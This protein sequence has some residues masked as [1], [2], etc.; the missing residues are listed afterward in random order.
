[1]ANEPLN[2]AALEKA[3]ALLERLP[4]VD[5]HNDLPM[6]IQRSAA[7]GDV[8]AYDL[9]S[10]PAGRNTDIPRLR[11]GRVSAQVLA[12]HGGTNWPGGPVAA[13]LDL[14]DI[15]RRIVER[16]GDVFTLATRAA[17]IPAAKAEGK[18]A[19]IVSVEGGAGIGGALATLRVLY[20]AG[21]R[22]MT[23][24]HNESLDWIDSATEPPRLAHGITRFGEAVV[25]EMNR[26]GM[27]VDLSHVAP[28]AMR[29]VLDVTA[30][31][32]VWSHSNALSLCDHPRNVPDDVLARVRA[33]GGLVMAT[34]IPAF[35][36]QASRDWLKAY[37]DGWGKAAKGLKVD[38]AFIAAREAEAGP[39]PLGSLPELCDH[40]EHIA[41]RTGPEHLGIGCDFYP[42]PMPEGLEDA[43]C[44]PHILAELIRR[45]WS[46][47]AIAGVASANFL[48]VFEAVEAVAARLKE[49]EPPRLGTV[50]TIDG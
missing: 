18:I 4:L 21:V 20:A 50:A 37:E 35:V 34:F 49:S 42:G 41:A 16:H 43:S 22:L 40:I 19:A 14:V 15:A 12:C 13:T 44:Y 39:W 32:V 5:A 1:M 46:D 7:P 30:A 10:A 31:P 36:S 9:E 17:D 29:R 26:L 27:I 48:R 23:L 2:D 3:L 38:A 11:A 33:N 47:D 6:F 24:T 45:G 28:T 8:E 25:A